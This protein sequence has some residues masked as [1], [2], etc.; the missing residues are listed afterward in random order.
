MGIYILSLR[1]SA[2]NLS[3]PAPS[4]SDVVTYFDSVG[5]TITSIKKKAG[6]YFTESSAS[7]DEINAAWKAYDGTVKTSEVVALS[8]DI[9]SLIKYRQIYKESPEL[10]VG[11][12]A[13]T[14]DAL[15]NLALQSLGIP[16]QEE[17]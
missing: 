10:A 3:N 16:A 14:L 12:V 6:A 1:D 2:C 4:E 15:C 8:F 7:A 5:I 11:M 9:S 13:K 17:S